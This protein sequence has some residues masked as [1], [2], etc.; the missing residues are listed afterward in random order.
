MK[1]CL[2]AYAVLEVVLIALLVIFMLFESAHWA[3]YALWGAVGLSVVGGGSLF[4]ATFRS[5]NTK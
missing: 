4:A 1:A 3:L 5:Q 2:V